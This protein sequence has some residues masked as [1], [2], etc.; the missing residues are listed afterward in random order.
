LNEEQREFTEII[1]SRVDDLSLMVNDMLDI[2]R[3]E[4]GL[5]GVR[6]REYCVMDVIERVRS[7]LERKAV[8][9]GVELEFD[10]DADAPTIY[11]DAENIGRVIINLVANACK[12]CGNDGK[13]RLWSRPDPAGSQV[14]F[15][16][17]DNGPGVGPE[18]LNTIFERFKQVDGDARANS[19][20]VG[21]GLNIAKELVH[22]NFGDIEVD[23]QPGK[24]S[25]F[26]FTVPIHRPAE[27]FQRYISRVVFRNG[28]SYVSLIDVG[29]D[30]GADAEICDQVELFIERQLRRA[31]LAF[32]TGSHSW[33]VCVAAN[34]SQLVQMIERVQRAHAEANEDAV[35][36]PL[37]ELSFVVAGTWKL[38]ADPQGLMTAFQVQIPC[39][40]ESD[41]S[42]VSVK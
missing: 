36:G 17:T 24:G 28:S 33:L 15:G 6:R 10:L 31:D 11:C 3:L 14:M 12:F 19:K 16:V 42:S 9:S 32:R 29:I 37:P 35:A 4:A 21:L 41:P 39:A 23:T 30:T 13:V 8:A 34:P 26:T 2:S 20:G 1:L 18:H 5:L 22:M 40:H 38:S 27:I 25:T 7:S